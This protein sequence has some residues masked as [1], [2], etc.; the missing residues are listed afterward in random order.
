[1]KPRLYFMLLTNS[2]RS[3]SLIYALILLVFHSSLHNTVAIATWSARGS[4]GSASSLFNLCS[5]G[6]SHLKWIT[7]LAQ[8]LTVQLT[9]D[10]LRRPRRVLCAEG[11]EA[12]KTKMGN[13]KLICRHKLYV[14]S[15]S[16]LMNS[17]HY[18]AVQSGSREKAHG[19]SC[20]ALYSL[21]DFNKLLLTESES[22]VL[23][24][25]GTTCS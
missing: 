25:F 8:Q 16:M 19:L 22:A 9:A 20:E 2:S 15:D 24:S 1:M 10:I 21:Q 3:L 4:T 17:N 12:N 6:G 11:N 18:H 5:G 13:V 7:Q 23:N 14:P